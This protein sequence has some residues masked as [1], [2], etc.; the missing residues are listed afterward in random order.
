MISFCSVVILKQ[1]N[2]EHSGVKIQAQINKIDLMVSKLYGEGHTMVIDK[3]YIKS[4]VRNKKLN[5][6]EELLFME[7]HG[8]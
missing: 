3:H 4:K 8:Q 2:I 1:I 6:L 7:L 5:R